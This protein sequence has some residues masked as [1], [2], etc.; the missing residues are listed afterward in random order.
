MS[1]GVVR[2]PEHVLLET[3]RLAVLKG[4]QPGEMLATAWREY[5]ANHRDEFAADLEETARLLR[6]GTLDE[7]AAHVSRD[8]DERAAAASAATDH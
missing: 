7:L 4:Q 8:A 3:K 1:S 6:D 5:L 2:V